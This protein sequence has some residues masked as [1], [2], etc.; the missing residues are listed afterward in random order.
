LIVKPE[1]FDALNRE[2]QPY[3]SFLLP[4]DGGTAL[5]LFAAGFWGWNDGI[6]LIRAG[7]TIDFVDT[8][9]DKLF[10]MATL[11]PEGHA[12]HVDDAYDFGSRA[13]MEGREWDVVSVDPFMGNMQERSWEMLYLWLTVARKMLTL[14]VKSDVELP[15]DDTWTSSYFPRNE[16]VGWLVMRH[17]V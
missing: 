16:R 9:A 13:A 17:D 4:E 10:E 14:T 15:E 2:A 1:T 11:M 5:S 3:P 7:L 8:D 12:F 6:H